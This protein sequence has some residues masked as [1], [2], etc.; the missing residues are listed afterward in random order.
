MFSLFFSALLLVLMG[1]SI[2][3]LRQTLTGTLLGNF[4]LVQTAAPQIA[5]CVFAVLFSFLSVMDLLLLQVRERQ[6]EFGVLQALGWHAGLVRKM[7]VRE[8]IV[9]AALGSL[10]GVFVA[11]WILKVQHTSQT[12]VSSWLVFL[13]VVVLMIAVAGLAIIP[14]LHVL[15][16]FQI[17]E[18]LRAE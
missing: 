5:G 4:V 12:L 16:R 9:V 6:R 8:G 15:R 2:L 17:S 14:A 3:A 10:P 13:G 11:A 1:S 7:L 18:I